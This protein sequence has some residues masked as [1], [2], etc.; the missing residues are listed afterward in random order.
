M[1]HQ[2]CSTIVGAENLHVQLTMPGLP[3]SM[4]RCKAH[5][6]ID[7]RA[8]GVQATNIW[9][10]TSL[11]HTHGSQ[12]TAITAVNHLPCRC[13]VQVHADGVPVQAEV[14]QL[15]DTIC[16]NELSSSSSTAA[17]EQHG[18]LVGRALWAAAALH[19][20]A[21]KS[22]RVLFLQAAAAG[23]WVLWGV[24]CASGLH[25]M[26]LHLNGLVRPLWLQLLHQSSSATAARTLL[27]MCPSTCCQ[28][29]AFIIPAHSSHHQGLLNARLPNYIKCINHT[30][31]HQL[32]IL[33]FVLP[34]TASAG[35]YCSHRH[36]WQP[37]SP[38]QD[39]CLPCLGPAGAVCAT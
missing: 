6:L 38:S 18:F 14:Q 2:Y 37:A 25:C 3:M 35:L 20:L 9:M 4:L 27:S 30:S 21:P 12:S 7:A 8:M 13:P 34:I 5:R 39:R 11:S 10:Q 36:L 17:A 31:D 22:Q 23:G 32:A 19:S 1:T 24:A 33:N 26:H 29:C 28:Q 15:L 16:A